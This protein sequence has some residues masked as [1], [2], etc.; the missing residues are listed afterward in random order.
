MTDHLVKLHHLHE[1]DPGHPVKMSTTSFHTNFTR[2][3]FKVRYEQRWKARSVEGGCA[4]FGVMR[5]EKNGICHSSGSRSSVYIIWKTSRRGKRE[6]INRDSRQSGERGM[7][8][9]TSSFI[10]NNKTREREREREREAEREREHGHIWVETVRKI[11]NYSLF[12]VFLVSQSL[13]SIICTPAIVPNRRKEPF[14]KLE[15]LLRV[16]SEMALSSF[17]LNALMKASAE[18]YQDR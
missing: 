16:H 2:F 7:S 15:A 18:T 12:L 5:W 11:Q 10:N 14:R 9:L 3:S 13:S 17:W 8:E 4:S 1:N 6:K